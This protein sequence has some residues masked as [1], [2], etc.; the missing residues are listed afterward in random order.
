MKHAYLITAHK[1]FRILNLLLE[2]LDDADN[3]FYILIDKK[4][5]K[6]NSDLIW[7]SPR[8]SGLYMLPRIIINWAGYSQIDA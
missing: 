6:K 2:V 5:K 1:N 3:D 4:N 8:Y 7:Y